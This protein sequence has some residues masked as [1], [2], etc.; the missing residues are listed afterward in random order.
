MLA[1]QDVIKVGISA[2][3]F[4]DWTFHKVDIPGSENFLGRRP[5]D[6]DVIFKGG[7]LRLYF[8]ASPSDAILPRTYSAVSQDGIHFTLEDGFRF[9]VNGQA[10][11]DPSLL[12]TGDTLRYF[13]GGARDFE[14]WCAYSFDGLTFFQRPN[15]D[16]NGIMMANGIAL[17][18]GGYRFYGFSNRAPR[19]GIYSLYSSDG[20]QWT[21]EEGV[22]LPYD[23][24][25]ELEYV[26]V[27]DPAIVW[28]DSLFIMYYVTEKRMTGVKPEPQ[29]PKQMRLYQNAPNP[30]NGQ[31][32]IIFF[33]PKRDMVRL[34]VYD[35]QGHEVV[36]LVHPQCEAGEHSV[37]LDAG[38]LPSG[39]Y[40]YS[41][42]AGSAV[43]SKKFALLR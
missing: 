2:D 32:R 26:E 41:L 15:L 19:E 18:G 31:T 42:R 33:L 27:K 38:D 11:L 35:L 17:P 4:Q 29:I 1:D 13:A 14:N 20:N 28:M 5:C 21:L 30:F 10:V 22:R 36:V 7:L 6:P 39:I 12:W 37:T 3:G 9:G 23:P 40:L 25:S 16:A 43:Q 24:S 8:T 34:S